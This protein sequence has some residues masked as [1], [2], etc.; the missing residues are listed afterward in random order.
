MREHFDLP[1]ILVLP[2]F[3]FLRDL[4]A[5]ARFPSPGSAPPRSPR[6]REVPSSRF[7]SFAISR[8]RVVFRSPCRARGLRWDR[9]APHSL[10]LFMAGAE[11]RDPGVGYLTMNTTG[12]GGGV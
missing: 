4:R 11:P 12:S 1:V 8:L 2:G 10:Y 6:P 9:E 3:T 7:R 5:P